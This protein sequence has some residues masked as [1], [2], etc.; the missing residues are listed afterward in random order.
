MYMILYSYMCFDFYMY[1]DLKIKVV[2][3]ILVRMKSRDTL[4]EWPLKG[5]I[6]LFAIEEGSLRAPCFCQLQNSYH[7]LARHV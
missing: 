2:Q 4:D 7:F 3:D 1:G 5:S 6:R